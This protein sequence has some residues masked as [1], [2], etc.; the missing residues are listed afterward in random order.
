MKDL[1]MKETG[2]K[3]VVINGDQNLTLNNRYK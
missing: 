3:G 1:V 2:V